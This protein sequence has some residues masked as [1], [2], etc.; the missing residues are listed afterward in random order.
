MLEVRRMITDAGNEE[1]Q[2][3]IDGRQSRTQVDRS[4][5]V[6]HPGTL[7]VGM[8]HA[9][10]NRSLD[11][12]SWHNSPLDSHEHLWYNNVQITCRDRFQGPSWSLLDNSI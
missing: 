4:H 7:A 10:Y 12:T 2:S 8:A 5:C 6:R 9:A 11:F 1:T 3:I